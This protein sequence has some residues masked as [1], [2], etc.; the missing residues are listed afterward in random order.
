MHGPHLGPQKSKTAGTGEFLNSS[1]KFSLVISTIAKI[2]HLTFFFDYEQF[3]L[4]KL[5]TSTL[6]NPIDS[7][8]FFVI[9][10]VINLNENAKR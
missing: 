9:D 6:E 7:V 10:F 3:S 8:I 5:Y 1:S 4:K 2:N